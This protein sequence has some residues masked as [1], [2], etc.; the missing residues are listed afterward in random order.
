M[1]SELIYLCD[2][3]KNAKCRKRSCATGPEPWQNCRLTRDI[4]SARTDRDG[5]P[6]IYGLIFEGGVK[7]ERNADAVS[8]KDGV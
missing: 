2:P 4:E 8:E 5:I 3:A 6:M 1:A 7:G